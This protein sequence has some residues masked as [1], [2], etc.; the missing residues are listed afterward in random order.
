MGREIEGW[1]CYHGIERIAIDR[2]M[3]IER[4]GSRRVMMVILMC[5]PHLSCSTITRALLLGAL[6]EGAA[7]GTKKDSTKSR[8]SLPYYC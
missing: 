4:L 7:H 3:S 5:V 8:L 6:L 2:L 1:F